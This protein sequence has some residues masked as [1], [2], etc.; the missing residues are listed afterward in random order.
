MREI[1]TMRR[2]LRAASLGLAVVACAQAQAQHEQQYGLQVHQLVPV[3]QRVGDVGGP[4]SMSMRQLQPG[5][6]VPNDFGSVYRVPGRPDLLMRI[7]GGL[8]AV[9][10]ESNYQSTR[11]GTMAV[12]PDNT[13]FYIGLPH[14]SSLAHFALPPG[15]SAD[16]LDPREALE[17]AQT[18]RHY[19]TEIEPPPGSRVGEINIPAQ[20]SAAAPSETRRI[21]QDTQVSSR[22]DANDGPS[23]VIDESYRA[24]RVRELMQ[25]ATEARAAASR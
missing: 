4:L 9:F 25:R 20:T 7:Q 3:E 15:T 10:P 17:L 1:V 13:T 6:E 18:P 11:G 16:E 8:T 22:Y 5:L 2:L 24:Q 21:T 19:V 12:I 14:A 23:I